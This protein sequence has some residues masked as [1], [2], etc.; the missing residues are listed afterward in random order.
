MIY[1]IEEIKERTGQIAKRYAVDKMSLFGSYARGEATDDSD[2]DFLID[3][4]GIQDLF[5]Y[6]AFVEDLEEALGCH[7]DVVME[8]AQDQD[9]IREIRKEVIPLYEV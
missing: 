3:R 7:V 4:G 1:T 2:V 5:V 6:F 9:F 8:S